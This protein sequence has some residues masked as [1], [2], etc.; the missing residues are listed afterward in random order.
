MYISNTFHL[1][2]LFFVS[3]IS[4]SQTKG[5]ILDYTT[6]EPIPYVNISIE[7]ENID[8][9]ANESGEFTLPP[10][11]GTI[12]FLSAVGY[13]KT[14]LSISDVNN[15]IFLY[16][17]FIQLDEIVIGNKKR[18]KSVVT[19]PIKKSKKTWMGAG[20]GVGGSLMCARF[21]PYKEEYAI[22]PYVDKIRFKIDTYHRANFNVRLYSVNTDGSPGDYLYDQNILV[23]VKA[24]QK[25]AE[26]N[27]GKISFKIPEEGFFV[28]IE[29]IAIK[30]N[31]LGQLAEEDK[32]PAH[33]YGYGPLFLFEPSKE[34]RGWTYTNGE[35]KENQAT[36]EGYSSRAVVE[37]T[38][39]D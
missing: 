7:G 20:G 24:K 29:H 37:I 33:L 22:T 32:F 19:N 5:K 13:A 18:G 10:T 15:T 31:R 1:V 12:L 4:Y 36:P 6:K 38:L 27:L 34:N 11:K 16:P 39:T 9:N 35:W 23:N 28:I 3:I 2:L 26:V 25:Y 30:L 14:S 8:F 17:Q 21:I